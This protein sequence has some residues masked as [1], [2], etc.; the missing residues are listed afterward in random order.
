MTTLG[1][2]P[3]LKDRWTKVL[4]F[5]VEGEEQGINFMVEKIIR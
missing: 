2:L 4:S 3:T 1:W 5:W